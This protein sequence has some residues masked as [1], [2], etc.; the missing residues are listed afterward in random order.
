[1]KNKVAHTKSGEAVAPTAETPQTKARIAVHERMLL[2]AV[3]AKEKAASAPHQAPKTRQRAVGAGL[4]TMDNRTDV[5]RTNVM[6]DPLSVAVFEEIGGGNISL[7]AR[8]AARRLY[9]KGDVE[10]F[11][12]AHH[13]R[14]EKKLPKSN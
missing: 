8:E 6:L 7:G 10:E 2:N 9:D 1:M 12:E 13:R 4:K 14:R 11:H 5:T 3:K